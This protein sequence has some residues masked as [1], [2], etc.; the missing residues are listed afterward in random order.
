MVTGA[1]EGGMTGK[2]ME[3]GQGRAERKLEGKDKRTKI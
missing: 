2:L 3:W 1:G